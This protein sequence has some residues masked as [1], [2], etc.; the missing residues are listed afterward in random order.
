VW[1]DDDFPELA[2]EAN[3]VPWPRSADHVFAAPP[4]RRMYACLNWGGGSGLYTAGYKRA[5]DALVDEAARD[6]V[7]NDILVY[8][9]VFCY[10]QYLEL[11]LKG[12]LAETSLYMDLAEPVKAAHPLLPLWEPL[13]VR[14][15]E[16]AGD[17]G[18]DLATA[19]DVLAWFDSVDRG[20]YAFRYATTPQGQPSFPEKRL[21]IINLRD[22]AEVVS[23]VG[24]FLERHYDQISG[25]REARDEARDEARADADYYGAP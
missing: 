19:D 1:L 24:V 25:A 13:R 9:I 8:P 16:L 7:D 2:D 15:R 20:S 22:L 23:R 12:L 10:R 3:E 11:L 4:D 21:R 6:R 18:D 5:G 14:L 17:E